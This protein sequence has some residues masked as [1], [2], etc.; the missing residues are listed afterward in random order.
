MTKEFTISTN[1]SSDEIKERIQ[2]LLN[3]KWGIPFLFRKVIYKG[4]IK[5]DN[6]VITSQFDN[7]PIKLKGDVSENLTSKSTLF[8]YLI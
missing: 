4:E 8:A 1:L 7:L 2:K 6:F 3:K 5:K